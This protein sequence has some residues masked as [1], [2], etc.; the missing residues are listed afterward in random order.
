MT[1]LRRPTLLALVLWSAAA[2][3]CA[4]RQ[5]AS[6]PPRLTP[7]STQPATDGAIDPELTERLQ[8]LEQRLEA[9]RIEHHVPGMAVA[10]VLDDKVVVARGFGDAD[11]HSKRPVDEHTIF[12]IGSST[13]AFTSALVGTFVDEGAM[14]WEDPIVKHVP[15]LKLAVQATDRAPTLRDALCHRTGFTRMS[16]LWAASRVTREVMFSTA[17]KAEPVADFG[18]RFLYNNVV[19]ASAGEATA[20]MGGQ[21]W[22]T[23]MK[24]R[25]LEPLGMKASSTSVAV[26]GPDPKRAQGYRYDDATDEFVAVPMRNLDLIAP[27][28]AINSNAV[29]MAQWV[30]MQ[31]GRGRIDDRQIVSAERIE[32]TWTPQIDVG[33]GA[34]YGLGWF[35]RDEA[36]HR[37]VEHGGNIDGYAA[38]VAL[39]PEEGLGFVLLT[40]VSGTP[41]QSAARALVWDAM[42]QP[43]TPDEAVG[44]QLDAEPY[45]GR[46]VADFGPWDDAR[47]VV[48]EKDGRLHLDV[49]LQTNYEL[50]PP[51][52][53]GH[54]KF[55]AA[56]EISASFQVGADGKA[57]VLG[58]H[59]GGLD[60]EMPREGWTPPAEIDLSRH[61]HHLGR[62]AAADGKLSGT[63]LVRGNRL[64]IDIP[65]QMVYELHKPD[66]DGRWRFRV[67]DD[68]HVT[69]ELGARGKRKGKPIALTLT[70]GDTVTRMARTAGQVELPT[71]DDLAKIRR[72]TQRQQAIAGLGLVVA[73]GTVRLPQ[74]GVQG[75][76][77]IFFD[78]K[79]SRVEVDLGQFGTMVEVDN[80]RRGWS[81]GTLG[82]VT[83]VHGKYLAQSQLSHPLTFAGDLRAVFSEVLITGRASGEAGE[84]LRVTLRK[85]E[86]PTM[87]A[88]V[89][90]KTGD[91]V[92]LKFAKLL[93]G[94]GGLP[95]TSRLSDYRDVLGI[96]LPYKSEAEDMPSGKT[97]VEF[98]SVRRSD[99]DAAKLFPGAPPAN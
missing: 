97:I 47:F 43:L 82:P 68:I 33:G 69:F 2:L 51:D 27:A 46:Y 56:P 50:M 49:P 9:A 3:A 98:T 20:R 60:F 36:G 55:A 73:E 81:E 96:R 85:D 31:L 18:T 14:A 80:G 42:L 77:R 86:L 25:L 66:A 79:R 39:M 94:L 64:A 88:R 17:S 61:R 32:D 5:D 4:P 78:S 59:Q 34:R 52:G 76:V 75:T 92:E 54:Y 6:T 67:K 84:Q 35:V 24:T 23:L 93:P 72:A 12:A 48:T 65:D 90:A 91:V 15:E 63:V 99:A 16:P 21:P 74:A 95:V 26:A 19:Y 7:A 45:L 83:E 87:N 70:Q 11:I 58:L 1:P 71:A 89:D 10:V 13:K 57:N 40:N 8:R 29:D 22:H 62:Y 53:D 38:A 37:V 30:R 44:E 28:G 41:L